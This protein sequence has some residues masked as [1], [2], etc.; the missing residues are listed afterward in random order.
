ML[1]RQIH[2]L[3]LLWPL[4][5]QPDHLYVMRHCYTCN[6]CVLVVQCRYFDI[7]EKL[8]HLTHKDF[9]LTPK[10]AEALIDEN[11]IGELPLSPLRWISVQRNAPETLGCDK[12]S[13]VLFASVKQ[14]FQCP[15][16]EATLQS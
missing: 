6:P 11:T 10:A 13:S 16:Y 1:L 15:Q 5:S 9:V 14:R 2:L 4:L 3:V 8:V 7:E 12:I